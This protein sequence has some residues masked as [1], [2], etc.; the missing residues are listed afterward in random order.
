MIKSDLKELVDVKYEGKINLSV[1]NN[2]HT[3]AYDFIE[4]DSQGARC[5]ILEVGCSTGYFGN[6]LKIAGHNVWGIE[7]TPS[8]AE[9]ANKVL[10]FVYVGTIE[11]FLA[12][13]F[14]LSNKFD[15][16]VFGDVL[17]HL[18]YPS[19]IVEQCKAIL[20]SNGA[21][22]A[23]IPNVAHLAV[24]VMLLEGRW[25]YSELGIMDNTHL[26]FFDKKS[27]IT[28]FNSTSFYIKALDCVRVSVEETGIE[29]NQKLYK[30]A[31]K[32]VNDD[33]LDVFQYVVLA[34]IAADPGDALKQTKFYLNDSIKVLCILPN[35]NSTIAK[36]RIIDPLLVWARKYNGLL[37]IRELSNF[38]DVDDTAW[39]DIVIL[40]REANI[41]I[42]TLIKYLKKLKKKIVFDIDDLLTEVPSF[43]STY[44]HSL[45]TKNH[46][47]K[48]I[49]RCDVTTVTNKK[50]QNEFIQL[51]PNTVVI[52]NCSAIITNDNLQNEN[53]DTVNLIIASSDTIRVD[54][55]IPVLNKL[56]QQTELK[57]KLIGIGP[58]G[59]LLADAGLKIELHDN[60]T[61]EDFKKFISIQSNAIGLIPLDDSKFS[62]CKSAIKFVDYS[63][64]G[65]VSLCSNVPPYSDVV[66][67]GTTGILVSNDIQ[68]WYDA[69][70][71]LGESSELRLRL[72]NAA[73]DYCLKNFSLDKSAESWQKLF[74][75]L[76]I[77][78]HQIPF[79]YLIGQNKIYR[80]QLILAYL[81]DKSSYLLAIELIK[82][83]GVANFS[84]RFFNYLRSIPNKN[85]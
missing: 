63:L 18:P 13:D 26:R 6:A 3:I 30:S 33:A 36:I 15:Y 5:K 82:K 70:M 28:M 62:S 17:E 67:N 40:Q 46:L 60:M 12:S 50:L 52:P 42:V 27:I 75:S 84:R 14:A 56:R 51:N 81:F 71:L 65:M 83:N 80:A 44:K 31:R 32:I 53:G 23:S 68:S 35:T 38:R 10:D 21:I 39:A 7:M 25:Q 54:F 72:S 55:I 79:G 19:E 66:I 8:A 49:R 11:A 73:N 78:K 58:P 77:I 43:L 48:V 61:H 20:T 59:R 64:S 22:V 16:I 45:R 37:R 41:Q 24:R 74:S 29:I 34:K 4:I 85:L 57:F 1:K 69:I 9:L 47:F 2:S 76:N